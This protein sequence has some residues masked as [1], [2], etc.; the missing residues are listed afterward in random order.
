MVQQASP[1]RDLG[2]ILCDT[3]SNQIEDS[4]NIELFFIERGDVQISISFL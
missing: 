4:A 3:V 2:D 1:L